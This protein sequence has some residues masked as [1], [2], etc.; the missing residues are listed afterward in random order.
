VRGVVWDGAQLV[1]TDELEVRDRGPGEAQVQVLASGICHSDLNVMDATSPLPPPIVLG[2]EAAGVVE[3]VGPG[4][5][6][7]T[8]GEAVVV[9][10]MTP[11]GACRACQAAR[12]GDCA[13]AFG[14]GATP[15]SWRGEP[16]RAYANVSSFAGRITV[17]AS[18]LVASGALAPTAAALIGC[19]VSTGFGVVRN[20]A[21]VRAGDRVVV[22]GIGGIGVN[23]L[24]TARLT[25]CARI[26]A[27]DVNPDKAGIAKQFGADEF[28]VAPRSAGGAALAGAVRAAGGAPVDAAIECSGAVSAIEASIEVTAPGGTTALVGIPRSGTRVAFD[29]G[30]L[31]RGRRIVGSLNGGIDPG[32]DLAEIVRLAEAGD[33]DL[34][35]QVS[36]VWPLAGIEEAIAAVRAGDVVRAALDHTA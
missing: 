24:Q 27:V 35:S 30:A 8:V 21:R 33:L 25:G 22:F 20:V 7:V 3:R 19:A 15:F 9:G 4:V 28:V 32:R 16:V 23:A 31:L 29:V 11:C 17:Q 26:I 5:T 12:F 6:S 18:Q 36:R 10:S 1:V 34:E 13:D 2:H 14:R